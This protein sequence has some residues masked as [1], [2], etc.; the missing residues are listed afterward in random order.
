MAWGGKEPYDTILTKHY[1]CHP[2]TKVGAVLSLVCKNFF[3]TSEIV[4]K[5]NAGCPVKFISNPLMICQE[6]PNE[7]LTSNLPYGEL[8]SEAKQLIVQIKHRAKEQ[9]KQEI[10][11][12]LDL[13]KNNY[14]E[15]YK[16]KGL[17][18]TVYED[19]SEIETLKIENQH[20]K[21]LNNE[22]LDKN[23][24]LNELLTKE[25]QGKSNN[26]KAYAEITSNTKP[27]SKRVP[28]LIIKRTYNKDSTVL[29]KRVLQH[30]TQDTSIQT[31]NLAY[32]NKDT[33]IKI[34]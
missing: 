1:K 34:A 13:Q 3:H 14:N 10:I 9:V 18:Y 28:K 16:E 11:S 20:P 12:E 25:K 30:L 27:K 2:Q 19:Y 15:N 6:H 24:I 22:V 7:A 4:T 33:L 8:S 29:E 32:K 23:R 17:N 21:Q 31:K 26:I 5:Y